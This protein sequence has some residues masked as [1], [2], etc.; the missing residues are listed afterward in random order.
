MTLEPGENHQALTEALGL[1]SN[2]VWRLCRIHLRNTADCEDVLQEVFLRLLKNTVAF[3]NEEHRKAWLCRVT[4]NLCKDMKKSFWKR[5]VD[6]LEEIE[7]TWENDEERS[8]TEAV[9]KLPDQQRSVVHLHYYE[10]YSIPEISRMLGRKENT[11]YSDLNRARKTLRSVLGD[12]LQD[13][14]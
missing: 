2:M 7:V 3:E 6:P 1:Y 8:V 11:L 13:W 12:G 10:G 4:L 9:M 14:E 5:K